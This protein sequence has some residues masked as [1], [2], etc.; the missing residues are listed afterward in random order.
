[1][2]ISAVARQERFLANPRAANRRSEKRTSHGPWSSPKRTRNEKIVIVI[3]ILVI[4]SMVVSSLASLI[5]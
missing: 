4:G 3:G 5:K 1:M 2:D